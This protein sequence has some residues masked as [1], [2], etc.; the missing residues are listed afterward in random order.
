MLVESIDFQDED[1]HEEEVSVLWRG[2]LRFKKWRAKVPVSKEWLNACHDYFFRKLTR[3]ELVTLYAYTTQ[4]FYIINDFVAGGKM[5]RDEIVRVDVAKTTPDVWHGVALDALR[6]LPEVKPFDA[7]LRKATTELQ[8]KQV[9]KEFLAFL[10]EKPKGWQA[11]RIQK[12]ID[13]AFVSNYCIFVHQGRTLGIHTLAQFKKEML[14]FTPG[15]WRRILTQFVK[16]MK[17]IFMHAPPLQETM[18][19]YR[20]VKT[21]R[22]RR[23]FVSTTLSKSIAK[24]FMD[25][26]KKCC[27]VEM[28]AEKGRHVLPLFL[29]SRYKVELEV[30]LLDP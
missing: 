22:R 26:T 20:G 23:G 21:R 30:L 18:Q 17:T 12:E 4:L 19:L 8:A 25:E 9:H 13:D 28:V 16:D 24:D 11:A 5:Y 10:R 3:G 14:S 29:L 27:V 2:K 15:Q 6:T 1:T 7:Q